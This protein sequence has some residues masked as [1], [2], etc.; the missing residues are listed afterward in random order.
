MKRTVIAV[1][2]VLLSVTG[3]CGCG[4]NRELTRITTNNDLSSLQKLEPIDADGSPVDSAGNNNSSAT[5]LVAL[6]DTREEAE[7]IAELYGIELNTYSYGV[8][9]YTTD[10]NLQELIDLGVENNYPALTPNYEVE[11][12]D[13]IELHTE[14]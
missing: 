4:G 5:E 11:L 1:G 9:T 2:L 10:K 7:K 3:L 12:H 14:Q 6:A 8:A 13:E